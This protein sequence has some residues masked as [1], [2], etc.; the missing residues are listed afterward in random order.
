MLSIPVKF[1]LPLPILVLLLV[2][3]GTARLAACRYCEMASDPSLQVT[4]SAS[5][6][7]SVPV[8]GPSTEA[9]LPLAQFSSTPAATGNVAAE[10]PA[11]ITPL[12]SKQIT[13]RIPAALLQA[14]LP[15]RVAPVATKTALNAPPG[16]RWADV[17]LLGVATAG[18]I[19]CWRTRRPTGG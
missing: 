9:T 18:G 16:T 15:P 7:A 8:A 5:D 17:G 12:A 1:G 10:A 11:A 2:G 6:A 13:W 14:Q 19:F 4:F 3:F